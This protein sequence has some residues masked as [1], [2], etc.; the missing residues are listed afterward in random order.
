MGG[1]GHNDCGSLGSGSVRA[2]WEGVGF[3]DHQSSQLEDMGLADSG[4]MAMSEFTAT[5]LEVSG[6]AP[7]RNLLREHLGTVGHV[8]HDLAESRCRS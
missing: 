5:D 7:R 8:E 2:R 3:A 4:E 6:R 1:A